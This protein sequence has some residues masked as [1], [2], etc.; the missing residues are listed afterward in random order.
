M[1]A[2]GPS[3]AALLVLS[4]AVG[5]LGCDSSKD[6]PDWQKAPERFDV[7]G[8]DLTF[9]KKNL[10]AF[11]KMGSGERAAH[12]DAL[13]SK[14]GSFKGQGRFQV[15]SEI[16]ANLSD[17]ELG[18]YEA[19]VLVEEPVLYEITIEYNL[20]S[21][22]KIGDGYPRGTYVEFTGTVVDLEF[23]DDAKPRKL[24]IKLKDTKFDRLDA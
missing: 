14:P 1:R 19:S 18:Q 24:V 23:H 21:N 3:L 5:P 15:V 10:E 11:N 20:L 17:H 7:Q 6:G 13:K 22:E 16:G 4:V 12:I 9:G 2:V 8:D